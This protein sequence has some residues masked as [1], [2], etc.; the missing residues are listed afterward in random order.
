MNRVFLFGP[1]V[2]LAFAILFARLS[3][4]DKSPWLVILMLGLL[5]LLFLI[6]LGA[7]A[8]RNSSPTS[9]PRLLVIGAACPLIYALVIVVLSRNRVVDSLSWLGFR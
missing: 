8:M 9:N 5:A 4:N 1:S 7:L 6:S 3:G 2:L